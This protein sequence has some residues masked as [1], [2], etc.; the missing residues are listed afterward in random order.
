VS[1]CNSVCPGGQIE[2][3]DYEANEVTIQ[4]TDGEYSSYLH[5]GPRSV[6]QAI[7][8]AFKNNQKVK[9][10]AVIGLAGRSGTHDYHVHFAML[11]T[12]TLP[13]TPDTNPG[14]DKPL[15]CGYAPAVSDDKPLVTRPFAFNDFWLQSKSSGSF[16]HKML[17]S[18]MAG[19]TFCDTQSC[20]DPH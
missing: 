8:D 4:H 10:G 9:K 18:V 2:S 14:T 19:D 12:E 15:R 6:P 17:A 13:A 11:W 20:K 7:K 3:C 1:G 5:L 16:Q